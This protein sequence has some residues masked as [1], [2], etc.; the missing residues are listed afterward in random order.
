MPKI[1]KL[2][3]ELLKN[4]ESINSYAEKAVNGNYTL[5][6]NNAISYMMNKVT[7][8]LNSFF[9]TQM[10]EVK[11]EIIFDFV[12]VTGLMN[13]A[14]LANYWLGGYLVLKNIFSVGT[15]VAFTLYFSKV[16]DS[17]EYFMEFLKNWNCKSFS[18]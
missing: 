18:G 13:I 9:K 2:N 8:V 14:S 11:Y 12:L 6:I 10:K 4:G 5:R 16:W 3:E 7:N 17:I 15:L 1:E